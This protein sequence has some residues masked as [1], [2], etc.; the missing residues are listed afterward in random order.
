MSDIRFSSLIVSSPVGPCGSAAKVSDLSAESEVE[1]FS[2]ICSQTSLFSP[3]SSFKVDSW[4]TSP[5]GL[6]FI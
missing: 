2:L 6:L 4:L 3:C 5:L 1:L